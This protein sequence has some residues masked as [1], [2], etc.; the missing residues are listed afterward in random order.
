VRAIENFQASAGNELSFE[1]GDIIVV[2]GEEEEGGWIVGQLGEQVG[3]IPASFV[4]VLDE[5][6]HA[7]TRGV[8]IADWNA[9]GE[10]ELS[11]KEGD[12]IYL[13]LTEGDWWVGETKGVTGWLPAGY[14]RTDEEYEAP[15]QAVA[16]WD[17]ETQD[18]SELVF[19]TGDVINILGVDG[20][21][22]QGELNGHVGW[23]PI[24]LVELGKAK[25]GTN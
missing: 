1:K 10:G 3:W 21:W 23:V 9:V 18:E 25:T 11:F 5:V 7:A 22:L 17:S 13:H 24:S 19:Q 6:Y 8:A 2:T 20:A 14:V 15:Q 16:L 4:E 12:I